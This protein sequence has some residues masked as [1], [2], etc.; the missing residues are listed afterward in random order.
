VI[1][2][3]QTDAL[4]SIVY[5]ATA[6]RHRSFTDA[7]EELGISK[8]ALGKSI[9]KLE[10]KLNTSLFHRTTRKLSLTTEGEAYLASCQ[11]AL[12][13]LAMAEQAVQSK[14]AQPSG[15]VRIDMPAA[16]G[17]K[18]MMPILLKLTEQ[19]PELK[20]TMTFN[21]K[22]VDPIDAGFDLAVRF[23]PVKDSAE[24][25]AKALNPQK[26]VLVA[27]PEY[28]ARFGQPNSLDELSHHRCIVGWRGGRSLHWLLKAPDGSD[29]RFH[30]TPFHQISDGDAMI[31][32]CIAGAGLMQFPESLLRPLI[33]ANLLTPV[34]KELQPSNTEL[35]IVWPKTR[36]L[37]PAVR[38]IVDHLT[39][40]SAQQYFG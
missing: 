39:D 3:L 18:V 23:G 13:T 30:P 33:N 22:V 2:Q 5:F 4:R 12:D 10:A 26:L 20:F 16:F 15:R 19:F 17:K 21:D 25:I 34:L 40:L 7:A 31:E 1:R 38:F 11:S 32:A 6:A 36:H 8:S 35:N 9:A 27:S 29:Q 14:I 37:M 28:L 24:L